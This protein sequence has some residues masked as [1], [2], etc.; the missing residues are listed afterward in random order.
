MARAIRLRNNNITH[1]AVA[2]EISTFAL[3]TRICERLS[4]QLTWSRIARMTI[5]RYLIAIPAPE[6][7]SSG[8]A[9]TSANKRRQLASNNNEPTLQS[10]AESI[11]DPDIAHF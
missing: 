10:E 5:G 4:C 1:I 2:F 8:D 3:L 11:R 6:A 9:S 7:G